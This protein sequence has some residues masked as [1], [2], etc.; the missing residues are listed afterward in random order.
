MPYYYPIPV[1]PTSSQ[2]RELFDITS[3]ADSEEP[4]IPSNQPSRSILP[5][6]QVSS[7]LLVPSPFPPNSPAHPPLT[8]HQTPPLPSPVFALT[9][10]PPS[11]T[12]LEEIHSQHNIEQKESE[13]GNPSLTIADPLRKRGTPAS[14]TVFTPLDPPL[15][16]QKM[17][18]LNSPTANF[19]QRDFSSSSN[20]EMALGCGRNGL[21]RV[22]F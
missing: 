1:T 10:S 17:A 2:E 12:S 5:T 6:S 11:I 9:N 14:M 19:Y 15:E 8:F 21:F 4:E 16:K 20:E 18:P 13:P 22:A 7:A 3:T